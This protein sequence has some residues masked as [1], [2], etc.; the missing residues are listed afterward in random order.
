MTWQQPV[1]HSYEYNITK[2]MSFFFAYVVAAIIYG[3]IRLLHLVNTSG[4]SELSF[5]EGSIFANQVIRM[6]SILTTP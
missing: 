5:K 6:C 2:N 3:T 4:L 1:Y